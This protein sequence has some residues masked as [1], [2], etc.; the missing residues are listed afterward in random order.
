MGMVIILDFGRGNWGIQKS[1]RPGLALPRSPK[2]EMTVWS[3]TMGQWRYW[4]IVG[5]AKF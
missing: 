1:F 2:F 3:R 4:E 5:E